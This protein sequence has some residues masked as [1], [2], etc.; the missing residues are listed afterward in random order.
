MGGLLFV[1]LRNYYQVGGVFGAE[2]GWGCCGGLVGGRPILF[3]QKVVR[4]RVWGVPVH[5]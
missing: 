2:V 5:D 1:V 4:R 3:T